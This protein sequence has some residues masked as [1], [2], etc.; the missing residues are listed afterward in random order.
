MSAGGM[1]QIP[2]L[3]ELK[4][5]KEY[6]ISTDSLLQLIKVEA[7]RSKIEIKG[8]VSLQPYWRCWEITPTSNGKYDFNIHQQTIKK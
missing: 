2:T 6:P 1:F 5:D 8:R 4:F 7:T 3:Q